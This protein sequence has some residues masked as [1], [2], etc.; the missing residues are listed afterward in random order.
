MGVCA[1]GL[2]LLA[3]AGCG[4][5]AERSRSAA[6]RAPFSWLHPQAPPPGWRL[7]RAASGATLSYPRR[8]RALSGDRGSVSAALRAPGGRY[9][10]YLNLTPRQPGERRE[11]WASFRVRHNRAEGDRAVRTIASARALHFRGGDGSCVRDAY[12][13]T[14]G[15]RYVEIACL[16]EGRHP[17]VMVAAAPPGQWPALSGTLERAVSAAGV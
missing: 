6:P 9:L 3:L 14:T 13:T 5:A 15:A 17:S 8:W 2:V 11:D 4:G 10:G 16:I 1:G 12:T 7:A